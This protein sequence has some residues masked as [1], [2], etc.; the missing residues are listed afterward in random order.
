MYSEEKNIYFS[1]GKIMLVWNTHQDKL[2][3]GLNPQFTIIKGNEG[4]IF[5]RIDDCTI[6]INERDVGKMIFRTATVFY[7]GKLVFED[8]NGKTLVYKIG[9]R[10]VPIETYFKRKE[11]D[12]Y[13]FFAFFSVMKDSGFDVVAQ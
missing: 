9:E 6:K 11:T 5:F 13:E 1:G 2:S 4:G 10:S 7:D 12:K 3:V 8:H